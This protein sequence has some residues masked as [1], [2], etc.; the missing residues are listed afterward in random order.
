ME[1]VSDQG[2]RKGALAVPGNAVCMSRE[3]VGTEF[4]QYRPEGVVVKGDN[5][6]PVRL[7]V[8]PPPSGRGCCVL[9][10]VCN[11]YVLDRGLQSGRRH[12][13][14]SRLLIIQARPG[15]GLRPQHS[16]VFVIGHG[17]LRVRHHTKVTEYTLRCCLVL[18]TT[19]RSPTRKLL[20]TQ[21][22]PESP[23]GGC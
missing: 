12:G 1:A 11:M 22:N 9:R 19:L 10:L 15:P 20:S 5:P 21:G 6:P 2:G 18:Q 14:S 4:G 23:Y 16:R 3:P 7:R 17:E 8:S 13:L